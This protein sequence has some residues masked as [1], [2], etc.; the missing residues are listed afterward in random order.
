LFYSVFGP[1]K[2]GKLSSPL[3]IFYL[4][5]QSPAQSML[6]RH[7]PNKKSIT[8]IRR[9]PTMKNRAKLGLA[10]RIGRFANLV[11]MLFVFTTGDDV[12]AFLPVL[13][14]RGP[15][16]T[17]IRLKVSELHVPG[18]T[19]SKIPFI[20]K[21]E[22][23][24]IDLP[25]SRHVGGGAVLQKRSLAVRSYTPDDYESLIP[26]Q[27]GHLVHRTKGQVFSST[28]CQQIVAE[29]E[30]IASEIEWT[31]NRHGNFPTTDLPLVELPNTLRFLRLAL[32]ERLYPLLRAQFGQYLPDP[33]KLRVADGFVVKYDAI[34]GQSE[35]K[36]HRD[37][38]VL[39]LNVALNPGKC[40]KHAT[41]IGPLLFHFRLTI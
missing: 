20:L 37:G 3:I 16:Y 36:P 13:D 18:Y 10:R 23:V 5:L 17:R 30:K 31:R 19:M 14:K 34:G 25:G 7:L 22:D 40:R 21:E 4:Y 38:S 12:D 24:A 35:L 32:E 26:F 28:E 1:S 39:S 41:G 9:N 2:A 11:L 33:K 29:A 6:I 27:D 8:R 15:G